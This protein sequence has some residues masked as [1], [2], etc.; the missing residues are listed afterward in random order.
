LR[1]YIVVASLIGIIVFATCREAPTG[2][3]PEDR[4]AQAT[5]PLRLTFNHL[6]DR[7]PTFSANGDTIY[8]TAEGYDVFPRGQGVLLAVPRAGG[9]ARLVV[10]S[11]QQATTRWLTTPVLSP[12]GDRVAFIDVFRFADVACT[13]PNA[14]QICPGYVPAFGRPDTAATVLPMINEFLLYVRNINDSQ[15]AANDPRLDYIVPL[16]D[17]VPSARPG[18][19]AL[20]RTFEYPTHQRFGR[21]RELWLRPSWAPDGN[22][23]AFSGG[24]SLYIWTIGQSAAVPVP[25]TQ[26]AE[27]VAWSPDGNWLAYSRPVRS[28]SIILQCSYISGRDTACVERRAHYKLAADILTVIHPDGTGKIELGQGTEPAWAA[29]SRTIYFRRD[30]S[31]WRVVRDGSSAASPVAGLQQGAYEPAVSK[32]GKYIAYTAASAT[33]S[34]FVARNVWLKN[35]DIWSATLT[36]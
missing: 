15:P 28:D 6:N 22:R 24:L 36:Q 9:S 13:A 33:D 12:T 29:D 3:T 34:T 7:A 25:N 1:K 27:A 8:Y 23:I 14:S 18:F 16:A 20:R 5:S 19:P 32:D 2:F 17:T 31:I 35:R 21:E 10:G 4:P 11:V 30:I 26:D